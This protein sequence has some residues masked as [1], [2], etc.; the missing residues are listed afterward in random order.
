[1]RRLA[2]AVPSSVALVAGIM[3]A[4][5][6]GCASDSPAPKT[7]DPFD[8]S[9]VGPMAPD[10][11]MT[12]PDAPA[13]PPTPDAV[14]PPEDPFFSAAKSMLED[15]RR[16]FRKET[17]VPGHRPRAPFGGPPGRAPRTASAPPA[18]PQRRT[19]RWHMR[20]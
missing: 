9:R 2:T 20:C 16:T 18:E 1:M 7:P 3:T 10:A 5:L 12:S 11:A 14:A 19:A 17:L 8:A 4:S 15:G 13:T 6:H